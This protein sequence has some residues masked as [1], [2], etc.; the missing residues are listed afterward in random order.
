MTHPEHGSPRYVS[1]ADA[2]VIARRSASTLDR[3]RRRGLLKSFRSQGRVVV[4]AAEVEAL[5]APEP[6]VP[7]TSGVAQMAAPPSAEDGA[8]D[9]AGE[10]HPQRPDG[11]VAP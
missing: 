11:E 7:G 4:L 1:L 3:W 9:R 10:A 6:I 5:V 2:A 8:S